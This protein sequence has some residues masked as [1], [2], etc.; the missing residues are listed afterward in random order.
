MLTDTFTAKTFFADF[1]SNPARAL[2]WTTLRQDSGDPYEFA[3][4]AKQAWE[5][6]QEKEGH[7]GPKVRF[8]FSD[9]L[10]IEKAIQLQKGCDDLGVG[11][12]S[13]PFDKGLS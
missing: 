7:N 5:K 4:E 2:R 1:T 3:R 9:G 11:G 13:S 8:I 12:R 10:D 6:V